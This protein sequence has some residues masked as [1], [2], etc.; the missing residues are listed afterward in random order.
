MAYHHVVIFGISTPRSKV[1]ENYGLA[2]GTGK[3][4]T[5]ISENAEIV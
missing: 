5:K 2:Q 3:V 4:S 1:K